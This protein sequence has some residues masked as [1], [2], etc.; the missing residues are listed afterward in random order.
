[1]LPSRCS[2]LNAEN[3]GR[4]RYEALLD[5]LDPSKQSGNSS[6]GVNSSV[7]PNFLH[8]P[9]KLYGSF[10]TQRAG[11]VESWVRSST[12]STSSGEFCPLDSSRSYVCNSVREAKE[13]G[14]PGV[15]VQFL[16][17]SE[18]EGLRTPINLTNAATN[19]VNVSL[20]L[21][22]S[23]QNSKDVESSYD[24]QIRSV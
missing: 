11:R 2:L 16:T 10:L 20:H 17:G 9:S 6:N 3:G 15:V 22:G 19:L 4:I 23:E 13:K 21:N 12:R 7:S 1:M 18:R 14:S 8:H 24:K 5:Q